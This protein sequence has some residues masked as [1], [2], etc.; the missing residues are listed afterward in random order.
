[1]YALG[2]ILVISLNGQSICLFV[3]FE[4]EFSDSSVAYNIQCS[5]RQVPSLSAITSSTPSLHPPP[6]QQLCFLEFSVS[7]GLPTSPL[8]QSFNNTLNIQVENTIKMTKKSLNMAGF[9]IQIE[10]K[11][12]LYSNTKALYLATFVI[13]AINSSNSLPDFSFQEIALD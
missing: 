7:Y 2:R 4:V 13:I 12:T 1:M 10:V 6:L 5:L 8:Y 9:V 11:G 3:Q